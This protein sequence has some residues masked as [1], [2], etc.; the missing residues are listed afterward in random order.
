MA[1]EVWVQVVVSVPDSLLCRLVRD[2]MQCCSPNAMKVPVYSV[3]RGAN[4]LPLSCIKAEVP[5]GRLVLILVQFEM[6]E[7]QGA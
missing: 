5:V 1:S 3:S 4:S 6:L 2:V 7:E